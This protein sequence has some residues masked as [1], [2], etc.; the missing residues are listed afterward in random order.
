MKTTTIIISQSPLKT[1]RVAEALRM[2]VGLTLCGDSVQALFV[3]DGVYAL[4][5]T[6]PGRLGMP[7]YQRHLDTLRQLRHRIFAERE[8]M[9]NR[10]LDKLSVDAEILPRDEIGRLLLSSD[11]V[12]RY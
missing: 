7:E 8:S 4:L 6:E 3:D 2:G 1:L 11:C 12:I 10:G 9:A 5:Q